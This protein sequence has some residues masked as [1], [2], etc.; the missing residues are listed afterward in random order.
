MPYTKGWTETA[1]DPAG[2]R[3]NRPGEDPRMAKPEPIQTE[4]TGEVADWSTAAVAKVR[5]LTGS[6]LGDYQVER[7]LGRGGMGEVYLARQVSLN[8]E[9]AFKVLRP[10]LLTN[11]TYQARFESEAWAAAKLNE[12]NI[13]HIYSLGTIDG[14]RYIAME[15]VQGTNLKDYLQKKGPPELMLALSIMRQAGTAIKA[16]GEVGLVHR[17]VKPEN[18]LITRKG[19][20]KVADFGLCRDQDRDTQITQQGVTMGT[21]LYMSPEQAQG[22]ALDHRSDLY[23]LGITFYHMLAG[24][25][26][27]KADSPL[28]LA[29]KHVKDTP[30]DLSVR[31]H[32]LPPDLCKLVMRLIEKDPAHRYQSASEM[33]RDLAKVREAMQLAQTQAGAPPSVGTAS[34][35]GIAIDDVPSQPK[36]K[37]VRTGPRLGGLLEDARARSRILAA[38]VAVGV[39]AGCVVGWMLRPPDL[40]GERAKP[41]ATPPALWMAPD[42]AEVPKQK[43]AELQYRYAHVHAPA[44]TREAAWVAV[45]GHFPRDHEW[46]S[47]AYDQLARRLLRDRDADRLRVFAAELRKIGRAHENQLAAVAGVAAEVLDGDVQEAITV[48]TIQPG[49]FVMSL[50]DPGLSELAIEVVLEAERAARRDALS[51]TKQMSL[52]GIQARLVRRTFEIMIADLRGQTISL[53]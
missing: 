19:L 13:V 29:L 15:Y 12:P 5:D 20:V 47:R 53:N 51:G 46:S 31:R 52:R 44:G 23:S 28:A 17:D 8:R 50:T 3:P 32:D 30:V 43:T 6:T 45:P 10:D 40:L 22:H 38:M 9:V 14:L 18:L 4:A 7:L 11:E 26:P 34:T 49:G 21:P 35:P 39:V 25:P 36:V 42:W 1:D 27:F 16:A 24:E 33:L 41:S 2:A 37:P 48:F